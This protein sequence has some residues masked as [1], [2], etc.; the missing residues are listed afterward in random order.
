MQLDIGSLVA[1]GLLSLIITAVTMLVVMKKVIAPGLLGLFEEKYE[2]ANQAIKK[3]YSAM[4]VKSVQI[5][6]EKV[7][8]E[9]VGKVVLN[10]Y[11]EILAVAEQIS[12]DLVEMIEEDPETALRLVDRYLPLLKRFFPDLLKNYG[13]DEEE[14]LK[15]DF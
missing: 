2:T 3:G 9:K 13:L 12:P 6:K 14:K 8:A 10:E 4:G 15:Y 7:M 5:K 1:S 11:P